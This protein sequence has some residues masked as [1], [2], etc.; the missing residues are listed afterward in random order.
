MARIGYL[1]PEG[2]FSHE[3]AVAGA[4]D[5]DE[6]VALRTNHEVVVAVQQGA[7]DRAV[8]PVEN[9]ID[10]AVTAVLDALAFDAPDVRISG[11]SVAL[12]HHVLVAAT[13]LALGDVQSASSH[14]VALAQCGVFL[15]EQLAQ[16]EIRPAS[17]T[18]EAVRAVSAGEAGPGASAI[19]TA[20]AAAR[21]GASVLVD[22]IEDEPGNRTRFAWL[23]RTDAEHEPAH[24]RSAD[25]FKTSLLFHG[26]GDN[27]P[28]W[29]VRCL[30]EFAFRGVNLS[31]IESRPL[32]L[33]LG[34]YVFHVDCDGDAASEPVAGAV[35]ALRSHCEE[36][37]V[38]GTYAVATATITDGHGGINTT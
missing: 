25:A 28:G 3:V 18:A 2:T 12:V 19:G 33:R 29:L 21:Y 16:A 38:L 14:P 35:A 9:M 15:R 27:S 7:V 8:A 5:G 23:V 32:R 26:A 13:P 20:A 1:G 6:L 17:S 4:A 31:R 37:R 11:E 36:V 10:G 30:S 24:G 34:H 22:G